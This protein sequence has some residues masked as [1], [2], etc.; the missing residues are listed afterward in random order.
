[1]SWCLNLSTPAATHWMWT[2]PPPT[3]KA[4][5]TQ[6]DTFEAQAHSCDIG[7]IERV[8]VMSESKHYRNNAAEC[9]LAALLA[10]EPH[11]R[12]LCL[13][14]AQSWMWLARQNDAVDDLRA[15]W[16]VGDRVVLQFPT[17]PSP[18]RYHQSTKAQSVVPVPALL[19]R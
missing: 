1:M 15:S 6:A 7:P 4:D 2:P 17:P 14:M 5:T 18:S 9:L 3:P 16:N 10:R 8:S 13:S 19:Q 11:Y 12:G